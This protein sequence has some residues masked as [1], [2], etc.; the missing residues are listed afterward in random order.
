MKPHYTIALILCIGF[1][2]CGKSDHDAGKAEGKQWVREQR[3]KGGIFGEAG[4]EAVGIFGVTPDKG[5][6]EWKNGYIEGVRGEAGLTK[7]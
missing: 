3:A 7:K 4:A 5:N 6:T 2:S 1:T